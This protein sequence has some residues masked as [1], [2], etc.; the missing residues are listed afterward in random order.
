[1]PPT[2]SGP[3]LDASGVLATSLLAFLSN[4]RPSAQAKLGSRRLDEARDLAQ[5]YEGMIRP[6]DLKIAKDKII[7]CVLFSQSRVRVMFD[8]RQCYGNQGRV[9]IKKCHSEVPTSARIQKGCQRC[10]PVCQGH[11]HIIL[12]RTKHFSRP[13][14]F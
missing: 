2:G 6:A 5:K 4:K 14:D 1:M 9:R 13:R 11:S 10:F 12:H 3:S 8:A 7:Q